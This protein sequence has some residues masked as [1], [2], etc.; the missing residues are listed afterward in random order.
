MTRLR[1]YVLTLVAGPA[2]AVAVGAADPGIQPAG[3]RRYRPIAP[4][5]PCQ[6]CPPTV[7]PTP[8]PA[9]PAWPV[10]PTRPTDPTRPVDPATPVDPTQPVDPTTPDTPTPLATPAPLPTAEP[11]GLDNTSDLLAEAPALGT[12]SGGTLLPNVNGD[13]PGGGLIAGPLP[14][15][16]G[17]NGQTAQPILVRLPNGQTVSIG[18]PGAPARPQDELF[19][20]AAPPAPLNPNAPVTGLFPPPGATF[21]PSLAAAVSQIPQIVRGAFK[22]TENESPRPR[23]R[24]YLSYYFYDQVGNPYGDPRI[25]RITLHQQVF[26]YEQAFLGGNASIGIRLPYNQLVGTGFYN[27]TSLGDITIVSK[28]L[29]YENACTGSLLSGGLVVTPPTAERPFASTLTGD[30]IGGTLIQ[31]Y[32]GYIYRRG[33]FY[34]QGFNSIVVPTEAD[35]VTLYTNDVQLGYIAYSAPGRTVSQIVPTIEAHLNVPLNHRNPTFADPVI[36][37]DQ[38]TVLG[39]LQFL[40]GDSAGLSFSTGAP[41]TGPRLFSLQATAQ[42]NYWF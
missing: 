12:G 40:L 4:A 5:Q 10:D 18:G 34:A 27:D 41:V 28:F 32:L 13:L 19:R 24:A 8:M 20:A 37:P 31:P 22:V 29:L 21:D 36:F 23:T 30:L 35:D 38:L 9:S 2:M 42:F 1:R 6:T 14:V 7:M 11:T 25:P 39:G 16:F 33:D 17:P 26:G 3:F 15:A